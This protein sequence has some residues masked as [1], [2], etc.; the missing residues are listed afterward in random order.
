[1]Y[2]PPAFRE[3]RIEI[4]HDAIRQAGLATLV[5]LGA[6][7]LVASHVPM[8]LD[9]A[10]GPN[11]TLYGHLAKANPHAAGGAPGTEALAIFQGPEAYITPSWY[12]TKRQTGK[13]V[14]T[15]NYVAIHAHGPFEIFNDADR[16]LDLVTR[17]TRRH[18]GGR[19]SPW[20][21]TDAPEDFVRAQLKGIVGFALPIARLEGKWKMNQNR[22]AGDRLGVA[23]GLRGE[24][25]AEVAAL[26]PVDEG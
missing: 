9:P 23:E 12:E 13:V 26:V 18:E 17:L 25:R 14:P 4:L 7:G 16:L 8:L 21:V 22:P 3:D 20:A 1:M 19:A 24:G 10:A 11:G 2:V 15:W 5:S 6:D